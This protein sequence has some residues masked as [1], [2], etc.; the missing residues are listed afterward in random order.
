VKKLLGHHD[1]KMT[2][3]YAHLAADYLKGA[4][5]LRTKKTGTKTGTEIN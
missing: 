4:V 2:E 3:R 1:M 5:D